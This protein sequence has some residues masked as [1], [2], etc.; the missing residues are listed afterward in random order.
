MELKEEAASGSSRKVPVVGDGN[1]YI[2]ISQ[3][4]QD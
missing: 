1:A 2:Y 4:N 3:V